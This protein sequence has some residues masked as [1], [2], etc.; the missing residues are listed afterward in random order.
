MLDVIVGGALLG[1]LFSLIAVGLNLEYG[2]TRILNIAH[3]EFLMVGSYITYLF[4]TF[5]GVN[6]LVSL[7]LSGPIVFVL[8]I[9]IQVIVFRKLVRLSKSAE[10]LEFRS[11]L[12]CFGLQF[13]IQ[14]VV[15][16]IF[17][18]TYIGTPYLMEIISIWGE[19]FQLNRIIAAVLAVVISII[20]YML[21][22]STK[23][24]LAMRAAVEEPTGA[25]LVGISIFKIHAVS[26]GLGALLSALA[27]SMLAMIQTNITPFIGPQFTFIALAI[28]VLG[29]MGSFT[30]SLIGGFIIGY[31][32]YVSYKIEPLMS[33]VVVYVF[34]II[35]LIIKPKGL[36]GR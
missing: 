29:G 8:G 31:I 25:Q 10:E 26:F 6:P 9:L 33:M 2:V 12:A 32:N 18:S 7:V 27:G 24:G 4:F 28:I 35:L 23:F 1:A 17:G 13:I 11:L 36:F 34:L 19:G 14:N 22:R 21:L 15:R 30:G 5:Y 16:S 3:G 20:L